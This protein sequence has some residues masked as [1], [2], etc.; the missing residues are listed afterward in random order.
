MIKENKF[1][2]ERGELTYQDIKDLAASFQ[3]LEVEQY[4]DVFAYGDIGDLFYLTLKG[5]ISVQIPNSKIKKCD[6]TRKEFLRLKQWKWEEFDPKMR[7][8]KKEAEA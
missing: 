5:S 2:K 8:A 6:I 1:F 3:F 4:E 7:R